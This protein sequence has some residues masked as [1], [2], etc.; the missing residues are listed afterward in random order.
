MMQ[1]KAPAIPWRMWDGLPGGK[2]HGCTGQRHH[3]RHHRFQMQS[4]QFTSG[5]ISRGCEGISF[6]YS[7]HSCGQ[8]IF[9]NSRYQRAVGVSIICSRW[10]RDNCAIFFEDSVQF[11][12]GGAKD[13][14]RATTMASRRM[15]TAPSENRFGSTCEG[16]M[17][18]RHLVCPQ[19]AGEGG[20]GGPNL[21]Y[22]KPVDGMAVGDE[23]P[24]CSGC[25]F[26]FVNNEIAAM[27]VP[28]NVGH[29]VKDPGNSAKAGEDGSRQKTSVE[30]KLEKVREE[31]KRVLAQD[32]REGICVPVSKE[33]ILAGT[34]I[35]HGLFPMD[36]DHIVSEQATALVNPGAS[37]ARVN[38][39]AGLVTPPSMP[40]NSEHQTV[41]EP[42]EAKVK[43]SKRTGKPVRKYKRKQ[44]KDTEALESDPGTTS[45]VGQ[46][47]AIIDKIAQDGRENVLQGVI[48]DH[49]PT[50]SD[51]V[52]IPSAHLGQPQD[53][54]K[55]K[56]KVDEDPKGG[57]SAASANRGGK[58]KRPAARVP[59]R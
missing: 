36:P 2:L 51:G 54:A 49:V 1:L 31:W 33:V 10:S 20:D 53:T 55:G 9:F 34:C 40:H 7:A 57:T 8:S 44:K 46:V 48:G 45:F 15:S 19:G 52:H 21:E 5:G 56:R 16:R 6:K 30:V 37:G 25:E 12:W 13:V 58:G 35:D 11:S 29:A 41:R 32:G 27:D 22:G 24:P 3:A 59:L 17:C 28:F 14:S 47:T 39:P 43:I 4:V 18:G 23:G 42:A 26:C 38:S 50:D